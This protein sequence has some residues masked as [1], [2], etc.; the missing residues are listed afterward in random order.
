MNPLFQALRVVNGSALDE[1]TFCAVMMLDA[2]AGDPD[3]PHAAIYL[4]RGRQAQRLARY[5]YN[6]TSTAFLADGKVAALGE[7][8]PVHFLSE[9]EDVMSE[10]V[11]SRGPLRCLRSIAGTLFVVGCDAQA[12]RLCSDGRWEEFSPTP[13]Q[14]AIYQ[15]NDMEMIDGF[16]PQELYCA[17]CEG[18]IWWFNG[19][20]WTAVESQTNATLHAVHCAPDGTVWAVGQ[21]GLLLKGRFDRFEVIEQPAPLADLWSIAGFHGKLRAAGFAAMMAVEDG[22]LAPDSPAMAVADSFYDLQVAGT[23][24]W[25]FGMKDV[26][27]YDGKVWTRIDEL[28]VR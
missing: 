18:V 16:S 23:V 3:Q 14:R 2:L 5:G 20:D 9:T 13:E 17:G 19:T 15:F 28:D 4:V 7:W 25:S 6:I 1:E 22:I 21:L 11:A 26:M 12:F 24:L 10:I 8:G 27:K